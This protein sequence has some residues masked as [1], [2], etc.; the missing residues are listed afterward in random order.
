MPPDRDADDHAVLSLRLRRQRRLLWLAGCSTVLAVGGLLASRLVQS[1]AEVAAAA[2]APPPTVLTA[3][4]SY[5]VLRTTVVFRGTFSS[6]RTISF[7]PSAEV[8][9]GGSGPPARS[10]VVSGIAAHLG[11]QVRPGQVLLDVSDRPV[12]VL[13]GAVPAFRDMV[14]GESGGDIGQLQAALAQLGYGSNPDRYGIFGPG[15]AAAVRQFYAAIGFPVPLASAAAAGAGGSGKHGRAAPP[16]VEVPMSEAMFLPSFPA[17][18][19]HLP[20]HVGS[21]AAAP[22]VSVSLGGLHLTGRLDPADAG[23]IRAGMRVQVLSATAGGQSG[24]VVGS[25]GQVVAGGS[26]AAPYVP[27][28]IRPTGT[29]P[30]SWAGQ[31]V[32]LTITAAATRG[33]VLAVPEAAVSAGANAVTYVLVR[34]PDGGRRVPVRTGVSANGLVQVTPSRGGLARGDRVVI[35]S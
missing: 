26:G 5:G 8:A 7:T 14:Q 15:T 4:V 23:E 29:W 22:L 20:G 6:G 9:P 25:V 11:T 32:Q 10:L 17:T 16:P 27:V 21:Q 24:G 12:F 31:N 1:P 18:V 28:R 30:R 33:P 19:T 3:P 2:E 13:T 34:G 35:G